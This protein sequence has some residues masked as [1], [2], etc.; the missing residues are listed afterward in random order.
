MQL[1]LFVLTFAVL[2]IAGAQDQ[3]DVASLLNGVREIAPGNYNGSLCVFGKQAFPVVTAPSET[4]AAEPLVAAARFGKGRLVIS[5]NTAYLEQ[6]VLQVADT[7]RFVGNIVRWAAAG[8][9]APLVGVYKIDGLAA[10]LQRLGLN[11]R[12]IPLG[13]RASVDVVMTLARLLTAD[14]VVPLQEYVTRGGGL[15]TGT[16]GFLVKSRAPNK[17]LATEFPGNRLIAPAGIVWAEGRLAESAPHGFRTQPPPA[18]LTHATAALAAFEASEARKRILT[19]S[20]TT[21]ISSTLTRAVLDMPHDDTLLLPRLD[22]AVAPFRAGAIPSAASPIARD[23][24]PQRLVITRDLQQLRWTPPEQ[25]RAHPAAT[26]FPG[27]VPRGAPRITTNVRI[28]CSGGR[29]GFFGTGLYAAPGELIKVRV[30][31]TAAALGLS[32]VIGAHTDTLR[33]LETWSRMPEIFCYKPVRSTETRSANAFGGPIYIAV[34]PDNRAG[35]FVATISGGV[36]APR[37]VDGQT[38]LNEWRST[39][40]HHPAPWAE[41]ESDKIALTVPSS[42]VRDLD[43]PGALMQVW[44]RI[45]DLISEL[46]GI[47]NSRT[48]AER[49]VPDVQISLG[50]L[51][52]GYPIMMYLP[53]AHTLVSRE[54]LLKGRIGTSLYNRGMWG[55]PHELG[56]QVQNPAW[57]FEGAAEPTASLFALY[58]FEKLCRIPVASNLHGSKEA[59]AEQIARYDFAKPNFEQWKQD[60]WLGLTTYVE[61]QQAFGWD[62]FKSVFAQYLKLPESELPNSEEAKRDQWMVRFSRQVGR[63]LG[64]F[65]QAWG[66]PTSAAARASIADLPAWMP[67]ELPRR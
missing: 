54:E 14:D 49:L 42:V 35:D 63:D 10:Q 23:D 39:I 30:P 57:S 45:S 4:G 65:F 52:S 29:W 66:I 48:R 47:P 58:V 64:P 62:G 27:S 22:G 60:Q 43:D 1:R 34:P 25:V 21:Q 32:I 18:E 11:A 56:H 12:D 16:V 13:E 59:R 7:A 46:A 55:L 33:H 51:H 61:L 41:I 19:A 24:L 3:A 44:N 26:E 28:Q 15:I 37:Y 38:N 6:N 36:P 8:K 50:V 53:K 31:E 17:D 2:R 20:E 67:D 5:G 9:T 40:R